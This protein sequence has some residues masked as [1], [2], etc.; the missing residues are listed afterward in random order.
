MCYWTE[1]KISIGEF[2]CCTGSGIDM[3]ILFSEL[4]RKN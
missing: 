3:N 2:N 1:K 4:L